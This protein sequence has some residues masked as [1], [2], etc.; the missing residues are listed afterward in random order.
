M[1]ATTELK[2]QR[3]F[4]DI[5]VKAL[6]DAGDVKGP[7]EFLVKWKSNGTWQIKECRRGLGLNIAKITEMMGNCELVQLQNAY[8]ERDCDAYLIYAL[9]KKAGDVT[10]TVKL[11]KPGEG[12]ILEVPAWALMMDTHKK[13]DELHN[14]LCEGGYELEDGKTTRYALVKVEDKHTF[15]TVLATSQEA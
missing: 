2:S 5:I 7:N 12:G 10:H 13:Y 8:N 15:I 4:T 14:E 6:A 3:L 1:A 11:A 9:Y